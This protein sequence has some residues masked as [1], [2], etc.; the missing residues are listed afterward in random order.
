[1]HEWHREELIGVC[2]D[3]IGGS[4]RTRS[5]RDLHSTPIKETH[6]SNVLQSITHQKLLL[7]LILYDSCDLWRAFIEA[8]ARYGTETNA[9]A[10]G[11]A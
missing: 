4:P 3:K 7:S 1:M 11:E 2:H 6:E 10:K 9:L 5:G 8:I